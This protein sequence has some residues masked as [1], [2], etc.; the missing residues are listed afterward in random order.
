MKPEDVLKK[1]F[2]L[3][4]MYSSSVRIGDKRFII[5]KDG[6]LVDNPEWTG[7][8][9]NKKGERVKETNSG[10]I[11]ENSQDFINSISKIKGLEN[12]KGKRAMN[13]VVK[14]L[15]DWEIIGDGFNSKTEE[16]TMIFSSDFD[17]PHKWQA[18]AEEF[19]IYLVEL[20]SHGNEKLR[21]KKLVKSGA[22]L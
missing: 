8:K 18:W 6:E 11:F 20:T 17:S 13:K 22:V 12:I 5:D 19:P 21:N 9:I 2:L 1:I 10:Q 7:F 3:K 16:Y 4:G 14:I 15:G